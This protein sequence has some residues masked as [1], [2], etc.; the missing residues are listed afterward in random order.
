MK[1]IIP[2]TVNKIFLT[3]KSKM[4]TVRVQFLRFFDT[5][6]DLRDCPDAHISV[7][8]STLNP[9][10]FIWFWPN[11][12]SRRSFGFSPK[13]EDQS[14]PEII[15]GIAGKS[16]DPSL[17]CPYN[18]P[19]KEY[20][21]WGR[22]RIDGGQW[23]TSVIKVENRWLGLLHSEDH[24]KDHFWDSNC[25]SVAWK[26]IDLTVSYDEGITW[27]SPSQ[28]LL[29]DEEGRLKKNINAKI[30]RT[31]WG[32]PGDAVLVQFDSQLR[33]Y[34]AD[35][36]GIHISATND[37]FGSPGSWWYMTRATGLLTGASPSVCWN[38]NH[39]LWVIVYHTWVTEKWTI[40]IA[41]SNN[42]N[43]WFE[44]RQLPDTD[45]RLG[46]R[47]WMPT[48]IGSDDRHCTDSI[49]LYYSDCSEDQRGVC[50]DRKF[51]M[52]D[53]WIGDITP[54]MVTKTETFRTTN[55]VTQTN[56]IPSISWVTTCPAVVPSNTSVYPRDVSSEVLITSAGVIGAT[57]IG[58]L[59]VVA[60]IKSRKRRS[61]F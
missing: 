43:D 61:V 27:Q 34:W 40:R 46:G 44:D 60:F 36:T 48:L 5:I 4:P 57:L 11:V 18:N 55:T 50:I 52:A 10:T 20:K 7:V 59:G 32:G 45:S 54:K 41:F 39:N 49:R 17:Y 13:I 29:S 31:Y 12:V 2:E 1:T 47:A 21:P 15:K 51:A 58:I 23:L 24:Y 42:G 26:S 25:D 30:D 6:P 16:Y 14:Y 28:V 53:V 35:S 38:S 56:Y 19:K 37:K 22:S 8:E 9:G 33:L 3:V